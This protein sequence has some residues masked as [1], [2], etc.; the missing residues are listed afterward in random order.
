[1]DEYFDVSHLELVSDIR[2][3]RY[4]VKMMIAW[5][6]ATTIAKQYDYAV[7]I[8]ETK[9]LDTW[10]HNISIQKCI[11]SRRVSSKTKGIFKV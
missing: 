1:M 7:K 2:F 10:T 9:K 6:F 3:G 5:Y 4:Y 11:E 8:F